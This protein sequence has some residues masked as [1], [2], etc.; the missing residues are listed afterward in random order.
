[1]MV[2]LCTVPEDKAE[3]LAETLVREKLVACVN[4]LPVAKSIYFWEGKLEKHP[5]I[6]LILKTTKHEEAEHRIKEL[7]PYSVPEIL[8]FEVKSGN[9]D[10]LTWVSESLKRSA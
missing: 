9:E 8:W 6:L 2:G 1:M 4:L 3:D 10:Y 7:H 5:E